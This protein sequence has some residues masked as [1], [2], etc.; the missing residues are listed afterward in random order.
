MFRRLISSLR[1][2][3][4]TIAEA[5]DRLSS[6]L[7]SRKVNC[8]GPGAGIYRRGLRPKVL[9]AR[10]P[11][12]EI[13]LH[14]KLLVESWHAGTEPIFISCGPK[15]RL[16]IRGDFQIGNGVRIVLAPGAELDIGGRRD[17]SVSGITES[18]LILVR[19]RVCI[20]VDFVCAWRVFITDC[21]WHE[22]VGEINQL[23]TVIGDHVWIASGA[24]VL[25]GTR[26]GSGSILACGA[27]AH[28]IEI[29]PNS[30]AGGV[31]CRILGSGRQWRRDLPSVGA[32]CSPCDEL[33]A[34]RPA[35]AL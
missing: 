3:V 6:S 9:I 8:L 12:A 7:L 4:R 32:V 29:P 24:S 19:R 10:H 11:D 15:A 34:A 2:P 14:G 21:D 30:L 5:R 27:V 1:H 22:I 23:D 18:S 20:G 35:H 17:E 25:K 13:N 31:P 16:N 28:R 33:Q 26:I